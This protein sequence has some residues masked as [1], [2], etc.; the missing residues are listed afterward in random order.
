MKGKNAISGGTMYK[1]CTKKFE[2]LRNKW[3]NDVDCDIMNQ[4]LRVKRCY[5]LNLQQET[6]LE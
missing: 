5:M 6:S 1:K 3:Q 4:I 2:Y